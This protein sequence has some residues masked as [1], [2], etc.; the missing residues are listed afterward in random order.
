MRK[1]QQ[2]RKAS[3]E[4]RRKRPFPLHPLAPSSSLLTAHS[5]DFWVSF[6]SAMPHSQTGE[7]AFNQQQINQRTFF[8]LLHTSFGLY[9]KHSTGE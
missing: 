2:S 1:T 7:M 6:I 8:D 3:K 5:L 4:S 9:I